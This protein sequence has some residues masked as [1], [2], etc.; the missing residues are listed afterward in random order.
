M[1]TRSLMTRQEFNDLLHKAA[2]SKREFSESIGIQYNSV[3][4]WGSNGRGIPIWV[5]SWLKNYIRLQAFEELRKIIEQIDALE[6]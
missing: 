1:N 4:Q 3:N 6:K 2:L 5:E